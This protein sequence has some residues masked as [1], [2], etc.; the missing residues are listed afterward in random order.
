[1]P[2]KIFGILVKHLLTKDRFLTHVDISKKLKRD[3]AK[4]SGYLEAMVD[5]GDLCV[6]KIGNSKAYFL[7]DRGKNEK[8]ISPK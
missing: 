5:Y 8:P 4:V 6:R 2:Q 3:K 7:N 1:M